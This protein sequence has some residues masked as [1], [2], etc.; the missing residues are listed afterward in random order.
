MSA[1]FS[2]A[3]RPLRTPATLCI[4]TLWVLAALSLGRAAATPLVF[5]PGSTGV[6][7]DPIVLAFNLMMTV[8][9]VGFLFTAVTFMVWLYQ[10][11]ENLDRRGETGMRWSLGWTIGAWFIP[12]ANLVIPARVVGEVYARSMPGATRSLIRQVT[13]WQ[14]A[15]TVA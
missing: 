10:A 7:S 8:Y 6:G 2:V 14:S 5:A 3:V 15:W 13:A 4:V 1:V 11:R 9:F 12:F